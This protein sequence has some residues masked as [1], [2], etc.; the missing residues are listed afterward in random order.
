MSNH[1][2]IGFRPLT[3]REVEILR[4][5]GRG[6]TN[7]GI[8]QRLYLTEGTVKCHVHHILTK[9]RIVSR[10]QAMLWALREGLTSLSD[11][12]LPPFRLSELVPDRSRP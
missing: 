4:L 11:A 6:H 10:E 1:I 2:L 9:L 8:A 12:H 5:L 7:K 3:E